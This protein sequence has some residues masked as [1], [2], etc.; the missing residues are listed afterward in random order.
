MCAC[1]TGKRT[2]RT[3]LMVIS[4]H[5]GCPTMNAI[6]RQILLQ[7]EIQCLGLRRRR[8][9]FGSLV[10]ETH[11]S[12]HEHRHTNDGTR[13]TSP[14]TYPVPKVRVREKSNFEKRLSSF[15]E[16]SQTGGRKGKK[17]GD[18]L[19]SSLFFFFFFLLPARGRDMEENEDSK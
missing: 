19:F 1:L 12:T 13:G 6:L 16:T 4:F 3:G 9:L 10:T 14:L 5:S 7:S 18:G 2:A 11:E 15:R 8:R 17:G